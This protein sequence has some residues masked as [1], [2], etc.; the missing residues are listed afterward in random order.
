LDVKKK[1]KRGRKRGSHSSRAAISR[2]RFVIFRVQPI[3]FSYTQL[4]YSPAVYFLP[5][6]LLSLSSPCGMSGCPLR[7]QFLFFSQ[8]LPGRGYAACWCCLQ[9]LVSFSR[10]VFWYFTDTS[11]AFPRVKRREGCAQLRVYCR[12][13]TSAFPTVS[14]ICDSISVNVKKAKRKKVLGDRNWLVTRRERK[15]LTSWLVEKR[16][17]K[18]RQRQRCILI[19]YFDSHRRRRLLVAPFIFVRVPKS[20]L[21]VKCIERKSWKRHR[22]SLERNSLL[23]SA[24]SPNERKK[25]QRRSSRR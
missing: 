13:Y 1:K 20:F 4:S 24:R 5:P 22:F 9:R 25:E 10:P 2:R 19:S 12:Q 7:P 8:L 6:Y 18:L 17:V 3:H 14:R 11:R 16:N 23:S 21:S 15:R